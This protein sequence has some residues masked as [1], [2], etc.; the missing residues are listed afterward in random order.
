MNTRQI[1][2]EYRLQHWAQI[3]N[4]KKESGLS[5]KAFCEE[6]G[7]HANIYYYWQR[8]LRESTCE[9]LAEA[10]DRRETVCL[11]PRHFAEVRISEP[12]TGLPKTSATTSGNLCIETGGLRIMADDSYPPAKLAELLKLVM[13]LC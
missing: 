5:V 6:A 2:A 13:S 1:A 9:Q 11:A 12:R 8:K 4:E 7:F 10:G 3:V